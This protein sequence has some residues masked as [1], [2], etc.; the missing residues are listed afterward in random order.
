MMECGHFQIKSGSEM[1]LLFV[2]YHIPNTSVLKFCEEMVSI[3]ENSIKTI[4]NKILLMGDFN[5]HI[6][7]PDDLNTIIFSDLLDSLNPR[8]N[9]SFQTHISGH[10]LDLILNDH[11]E[12][13]VKCEKRA[14]LCGSQSGTSNYLHEEMQSN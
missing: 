3:F 1:V 12:S 2:I 5:I 14:L 7:R 6:G 9:I 8:N 10:T 4:R 11:N 13:L